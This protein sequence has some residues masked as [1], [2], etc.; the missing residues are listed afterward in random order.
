MQ[1]T[2]MQAVNGRSKIQSLL[3]K[4]KVSMQHNNATSQEGMLNT[5]QNK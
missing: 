2:I 1:H 3:P 4:L 5:Q